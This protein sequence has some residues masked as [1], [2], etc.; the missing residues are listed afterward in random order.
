LHH[1]SFALA[2]YVTAQV[3]GRRLDGGSIDPAERSAKDNNA[4]WNLNVRTGP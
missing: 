1:T 4:I 2:E 3:L